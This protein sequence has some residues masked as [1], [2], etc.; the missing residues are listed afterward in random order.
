[1][2]KINRTQN[3]SQTKKA[4]KRIVTSFNAISQYRSVRLIVDVDCY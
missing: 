2:I 4:V 1:M 3:L